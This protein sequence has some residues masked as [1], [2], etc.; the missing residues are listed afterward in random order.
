MME[1]IEVQSRSG[2]GSRAVA[3]LRGQGLIPAVLYGHGEAN[4]CLAV[5]R[6]ALDS[7]IKH[8]TKLVN[9]TGA[10]KD[11]AILREV[12]WDTYAT[13]ILHVDFA[14]VSA[15]E[16]VTITLPVE[17]HGEAPGLNEGGQLRFATHELTI[18]CPAVR[19]PESIRVTIS[20]LGL[21]Q[22]IHA[23]EV[24]LPEGAKMITPNEVVVVTVFKPAGEATAA[25]DAP[26]AAT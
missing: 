21:G 8:G 7:L 15:S 23:S 6:E 11:T 2:V 20:H 17:L 5:K 13:E 9:L 16:M 26:A 3:R 4:V 12:Q 25:A 24:T 18:A 10:A 19:I 1:N 22:A 14:R